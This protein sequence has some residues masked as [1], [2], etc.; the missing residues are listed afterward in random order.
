MY[1]NG[2]VDRAVIDT[3]LHTIKE[4]F[5]SDSIDRKEANGLIHQ[6]FYEV[7]LAH[8]ELLSHT[9]IMIEIFCEYFLRPL[10]SMTG[11]HA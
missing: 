11:I 1:L 5:D 10:Y 9:D 4:F 7:G 8:S 6:A 3:C 2:S